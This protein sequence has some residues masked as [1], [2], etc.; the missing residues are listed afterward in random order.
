MG[1]GSGAPPSEG[2]RRGDG[3]SVTRKP[4]HRAPY[5]G[6]ESRDVFHRDE[7]G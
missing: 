4:E 3:L 5:G 1:Q 2:D 6:E 7:T